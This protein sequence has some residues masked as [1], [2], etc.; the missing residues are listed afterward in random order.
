[1]PQSNYEITSIAKFECNPPDYLEDNDENS[2]DGNSSDQ[3]SCDLGTDEYS[4]R[5]INLSLKAIPII[6][7]LP[8]LETLFPNQVAE[9]KGGLMLESCEKNLEQFALKLINTG[10]NFNNINKKTGDNAL[11]ISCRNGMNKIAYELISNNKIDTDRVNNKGETALIWACENCM[12]DI[13]K[14]LIESGKSKPEQ[15][16]YEGNTALTLACQ[17]ELDEVALMLIQTKGSLP[18][19]INSQGDTPLLIACSNGLIKVAI[20]LIKTCDFN[21]RHKNKKGINIINLIQ[22]NDKLINV[23]YELIKVC[24]IYPPINNNLI[25]SNYDNTICVCC[26]DKGDHLYHLLPCDHAFCVHDTCLGQLIDCPYCR[27]KITN[28]RII[29]LQ[30]VV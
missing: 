4:E 22:N 21:P 24:P 28:K 10:S 11:I 30:H 7:D 16:D 19:H 26:F 18:S 15:V 3:D 6:D 12:I 25:Q 9:L 27:K 23:L 1:M 17:N 8:I 2:Q 5:I 13:A 20:E 29:Y 14:L